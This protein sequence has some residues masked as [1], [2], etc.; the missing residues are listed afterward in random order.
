MK[1][2]G[3]MHVDLHAV[4]KN[5]HKRYKGIPPILNE[6][7]QGNVSQGNGKDVLK[8]LCQ[9][10]KLNPED[11]ITQDLVKALIIELTILSFRYNAVCKR[12]LKEDTIVRYDSIPKNIV[13]DTFTVRSI[14]TDFMV[15]LTNG[16]VCHPIWII[17]V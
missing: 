10:F 16:R 3:I 9:V 2:E 17:P 15:V 12:E 5:A 4:V 8:Q 1:D 13:P 7:L 14:Q 6:D 11:F